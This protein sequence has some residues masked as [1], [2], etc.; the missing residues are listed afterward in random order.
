MKRQ[1]IL[2]SLMAVAMIMASP[3][4]GA[5]YVN[6]TDLGNGVIEVS[7]DSAEEEMRVRAFQLDI[8]VSSGIITSVGDFNRHYYV[9]PTSIVIDAEGEVLDW[10]TPVA[11]SGY[12]GTL[13][14]LGTSGMTIEMGA[15]YIGEANAPPRVGSLLTFTISAACDITVEENAIRG[16]VVM[17]DPDYHPPVY[18]TGVEGV[19]PPEPEEYGGGSG[20]A[21]DPFL[22]LDANQINGIGA[23][24]HDW[25]KHFKLMADID[26][27]C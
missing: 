7:Y 16:G 1:P 21:P 5:V 2:I 23:R 26:L 11:A 6:C 24:P 10:G 12:P 13:G 22:I 19:L 3:A 8:R 9:Y 27:S 17:E 15:L 18:I 25:Y 20:T 4:P 14:G